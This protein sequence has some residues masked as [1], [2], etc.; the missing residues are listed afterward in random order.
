MQLPDRCVPQQGFANDAH[1][2][3]S[4]CCLVTA[5]DHHERAD[6]TVT[7]AGLL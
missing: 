3:P 6:F 5:I 4:F 2:R 7:S 1:D